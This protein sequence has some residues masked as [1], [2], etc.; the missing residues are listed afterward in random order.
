MVHGLLY[1]DVISCVI[2][3]D[4]GDGAAV[5]ELLTRERPAEHRP[6]PRPALGGVEVDTET[7]AIGPFLGFQLELQTTGSECCG[8]GCGW[9]CRMMMR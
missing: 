6:R 3:I 8:Y 1:V 4:P 9:C 5:A 7:I 2:T